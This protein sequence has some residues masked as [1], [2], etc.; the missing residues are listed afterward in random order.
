[1]K[2]SHVYSIRI[3]HRKWRRH[4]RQKRK[5]YWRHLAVFGDSVVFG[6]KRQW[7]AN[8]REIRELFSQLAEMFS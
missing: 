8:L 1:M 5:H 2:D 7:A 4:K 3:T 6:C